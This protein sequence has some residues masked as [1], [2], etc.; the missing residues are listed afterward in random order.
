MKSCNFAECPNS[1]E[2]IVEERLADK[3]TRTS[4][5]DGVFGPDSRQ[6]LCAELIISLDN[7]NQKHRVSY[8]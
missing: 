5:F 8:K 2:V 7:R 3:I 6:K 1:R 4:V